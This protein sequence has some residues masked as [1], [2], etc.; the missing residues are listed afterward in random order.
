MLIRTRWRWTGYPTALSEP[1]RH[2]AREDGG[3][4]DGTRQDRWTATGNAGSPADVGATDARLYLPA[5][6]TPETAA[7]FRIT[8]S[9]R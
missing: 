6:G 9:E 2:V 5:Q 3:E 8:R 7:F 4:V 1:P